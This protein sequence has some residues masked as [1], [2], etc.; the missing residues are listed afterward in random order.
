M[1]EEHPSLVHLGIRHRGP[2]LRPAEPQRFKG[3]A[4]TMIAFAPKSTLIGSSPLSTAS[5]RSVSLH[6]EILIV[7]G[8]ATAR[9]V[10]VHP[11]GQLSAWFKRRRKPRVPDQNSLSDTRLFLG[12]LNGLTSSDSRAVHNV[13]KLRIAR[14]DIVLHPVLSD[15]LTDLTENFLGTSSHRHRL[16]RTCR[17][18]CL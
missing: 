10:F 2:A 18:K 9:R 7:G 13:Q 14:H 11:C 16:W 4:T 8:K 12:E 3:K 6:H 17:S 1:T 5:P 15:I